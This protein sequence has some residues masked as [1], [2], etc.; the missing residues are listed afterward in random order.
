MRSGKKKR[1]IEDKIAADSSFAKTIERHKLM[2][3][4][5]RYLGRKEMLDKVEKWDLGLID[6]IA[7]YPEEIKK[8][9]KR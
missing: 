7:I 5:I 3:N 8:S 9:T 1:L 2:I 6:K 4:G